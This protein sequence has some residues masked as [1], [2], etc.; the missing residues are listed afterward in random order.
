MGSSF[1][2][3][4]IVVVSFQSAVALKLAK[5]RKYEHAGNSSD[6]LRCAIYILIANEC[7]YVR[8]YAIAYLEAVSATVH[9]QHIPGRSLFAGSSSNA[10]VL[11]GKI[12]TNRD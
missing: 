10:P 12:E 7:V 3:I 9:Q 11:H 8:K 1:L 6:A 2:L 5:K 4:C